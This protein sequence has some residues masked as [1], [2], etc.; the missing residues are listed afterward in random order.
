VPGDVAALARVVQSAR[1]DPESQRRP[2]TGP[3]DRLALEGAAAAVL[4]L[5]AI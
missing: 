2:A 1:L 3:A 5:W 4:P